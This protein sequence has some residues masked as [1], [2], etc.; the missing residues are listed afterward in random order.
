MK[1]NPD[2]SERSRYAALIRKPG[3]VRR[4]SRDEIAALEHR[5]NLERYLKRER[6]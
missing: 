4:L 2:A 5:R 3:P 6:A 1:P